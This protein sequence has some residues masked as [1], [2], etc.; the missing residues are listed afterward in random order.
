MVNDIIE[1]VLWGNW[2]ASWRRRKGSPEQKNE[3]SAPV[4][5]TDA[6]LITSVRALI[7]SVRAP[8]L[9]SSYDTYICMYIHREKKSGAS[10]GTV[11]AMRGKEPLRATS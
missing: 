2:E 9:L 10:K 11:L 4:P 6:S 8:A 1:N 5:P 3:A 7:V